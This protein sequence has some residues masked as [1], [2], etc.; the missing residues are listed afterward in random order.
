MLEYGFSSLTHYF[1]G[2]PGSLRYTVP[3]IGGTVDYVTV[4][5]TAPLS[6]TLPADAPAPELRVELPRMLYAP[7]S[8]EG[9]IGR[10]L[11]YAENEVVAESPLTAVFAVEAPEPPRGLLAWL[12]ALFGEK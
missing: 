2:E 4:V 7:V 1:L 5:N 8:A 6:I 10:L 3:V 9:T 12:R 11:L